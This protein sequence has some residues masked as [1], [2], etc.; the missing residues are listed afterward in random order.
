MRLL[1]AAVRWLTR[2]EPN[3]ATIT[4]VTTTGGTTTVIIIAGITTGAIITRPEA[5]RR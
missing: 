3:I 4:A 1:R 2:R 5:R